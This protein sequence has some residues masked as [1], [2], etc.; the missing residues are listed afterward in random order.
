MS[1]TKHKN[2][3]G[4]FKAKEAIEVIRDIKG[5]SKN[6]YIEGVRIFV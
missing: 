3:T 6:Q 1:E 5:T 2:F 4:E